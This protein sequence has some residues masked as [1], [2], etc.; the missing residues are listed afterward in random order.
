V[1]HVEVPSIPLDV[2][3]SAAG[4]AVVEFESPFHAN[5]QLYRLKTLCLEVPGSLLLRPLFAHK[6]LLS[7]GYRWGADPRM[8]GHLDL[9]LEESGVEVTV[10]ISPHFAQPGTI[11]FD[12]ALQWRREIAVAAAA[13]RSLC[14]RHAR[15]LAKDLEEAGIAG[16]KSASLPMGADCHAS[17]S[18]AT[19]AASSRCVWITGVPPSARRGDD[20]ISQASLLCAIFDQFGYP[21][22]AFMQVDPVTGL[23]TGHAV[24]WME[25]YTTAQAVVD[26]LSDMMFLIGGTPRPMVAK[27]AAAGGPWGSQGAF[28]K[29]LAER[30]ACMPAVLPSVGNGKGPGFRLV[31]VQDIAADDAHSP[32]RDRRHVA[33]MRVRRLLSRHFEE[34]EQLRQEAIRRQW[35]LHKEHAAC[36]AVEKDKLDRLKKLKDHPLMR[37][38]R[39][40]H[41]V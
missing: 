17:A 5:E 26:N 12:Q 3:E 25:D 15:E 41:G 1:Q 31:E 37:Q 8:P 10:N 18:A 13:K 14:E 2:G 29:A 32:L 28:D 38:A 21:Q 19:A 30:G 24:I 34:R 40:A 11:E 7:E 9:K 22:E 36:Y 6:P 33:A 20:V 35:V 39:E 23:P 27:M 16:L 4:Y